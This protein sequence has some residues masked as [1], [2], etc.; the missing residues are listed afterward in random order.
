[1]NEGKN[2]EPFG[3]HETLLT[4]SPIYKEIHESQ[5]ERGGWRMSKHFVNWCPDN[6]GKTIKRLFSY[7]KFNKILLLVWGI[8][9]IILSSIAQIG[10][11]AMLSPHYRYLS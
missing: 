6:T 1:M 4:I 10:T 2:I 3:V 9:F 7:L 11:N 5:K 8:I